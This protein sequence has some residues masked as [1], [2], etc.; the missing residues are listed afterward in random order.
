M[1]Q[2]GMGLICALILAA[3]GGLITDVQPYLVW[4]A[5]GMAAF[6]VLGL[7]A[8][9]SLARSRERPAGRVAA[10]AAGDDA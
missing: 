9:R 4:S 3:I 2:E 10:I 6:G 5:V 7:W 8:A 1:L